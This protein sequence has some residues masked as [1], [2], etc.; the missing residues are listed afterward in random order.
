MENNIIDDLEDNYDRINS[1]FNE[2][3]KIKEDKGPPSS[4]SKV[5]QILQIVCKKKNYY[6]YAF[7]LS[8]IVFLY[9]RPGFIMSVKVEN[10]A[11]VKRISIIK[12]FIFSLILCVISAS[13]IIYFTK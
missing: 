5:K 2:E 8:L 1:I 11:S 13:L 9:F 4:S 6:I 12:L 3:Y 10:A 7:L